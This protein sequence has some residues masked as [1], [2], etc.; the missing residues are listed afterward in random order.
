MSNR[1]FSAVAP[2]MATAVSAETTCVPRAFRTRQDVIR[3][4]GIG[5]LIVLAS[6]WVAWLGFRTQVMGDYRNWFGPSTNALLDGHLG[7]FF[8]HLPTDGAGG[9]ILL[10]AP[11]S[12]LG[13]VLVGDEHA[14]F[15][16]GALF[17][18]LATVAVAA[19]MPG[20]RAPSRPGLTRGVLIVVFL[21]TPAILDAV[22]YGHP[23]E[24]L[25]AALCIGS[26]LLAGNGRSELSGLL[27]GL[28]IINKPWGVLAI[29]PALLAARE[30]RVRLLGLAVLIAGGWTLAT[31]VGSPTNFRHSLSISSNAAVAHPQDLWWPLAHLRLAAGTTPWYAPPALI[32]DHART[33]VV[34]LAIPLALPVARRRTRTVDDALALLALLFLLRCV[35]DP[36]NHVYY[37]V[38]FVLGLAAWEA[39]V[40]GIPVLSL[41]SLAGFWLIFHTVSGTGSLTAQYLAYMALVVPLVGYLAAVI[42]GGRTGI[43]QRRDRHQLRP[44]IPRGVAS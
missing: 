6:V 22:F 28:A 17:C 13:R 25:G 10:R 1:G 14:I 5:G 38:P 37:Q 43:V 44:G 19:L 15:R 26:V 32:A 12:W 40:R 36:S 29:L 21:L 20:V 8:A 11:F 3:L 33:L 2:L 31:Y 18:G 4:L 42:V 9:S 35:L 34:L 16:F 39:R 41:V 7:A 30:H 24:G 27:L 23:E